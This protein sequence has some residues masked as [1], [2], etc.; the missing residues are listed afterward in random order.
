MRQTLIERVPLPTLTPSG[1]RASPARIEYAS[2]HTCIDNDPHPLLE[3]SSVF[4]S[5]LLPLCRDKTQ[6]PQRCGVC[7]DHGPYA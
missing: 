4:C 1:A 7:F 2:L 6:Y 5:L 3:R